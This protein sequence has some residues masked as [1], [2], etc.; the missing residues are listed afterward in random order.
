MLSRGRDSAT[1]RTA[2]AT[3]LRPRTR[4]ASWRNRKRLSMGEVESRECGGRGAGGVGRGLT[5]PALKAKGLDFLL[6]GNEKPLE[7][8]VT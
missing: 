4:S 2:D 5:L 8:E 6:S 1:D 3:A 7:L